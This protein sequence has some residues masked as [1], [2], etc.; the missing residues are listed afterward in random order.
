MINRKLYFFLA[1]F[2]ALNCSV[3]AQKFSIGPAIGGHAYTVAFHH[4]EEKA[5][6]DPKPKLGYRGGVYISFP[7]ENNFEWAAEGYYSR[8]GR[9]VRIESENMT[10]D[11]AY[12][13]FEISV[14][15]R[16][17]YDLTVIKGVPGKFFFN[18]GPNVNY[19]INGKGT[20]DA[21]VDLEY[22]VK[23][24]EAN[25]DA[26]L[27]YITDANRWLFGLELGAGIETRLY[28]TQFFQFE[29]RFTYGQTY[30]GGKDSSEIPIILG[31]QD[32]LRSNYRVLS[33]IVRYGIDIDL[34]NARKG[35][36]TLKVK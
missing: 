29:F 5:L 17:K 8:K 15:L 26:T 10:N 19:W 1:L 28:K 3:L 16:K 12:N 20:L 31:Y 14:L 36:S 32:S 33:F 18:I 34:K 21:N 35:K 13:F 22:E 25:G 24:H 9:K 2:S 11:A 23:F 6:F 30:L 27:N 7:L 4:E